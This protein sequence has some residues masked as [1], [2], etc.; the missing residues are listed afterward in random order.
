MQYDY[1]VIILNYNSFELLDRA[2][3]TVRECAS[4]TYRICIVDNCSSRKDEQEELMT[5]KADDVDILLLN[6][7]D[8]YGAGNNRAFFYLRKKYN[9][10]FTVIMNPDIELLDNN[11][12]E[13]IIK[14]AECNNAVGGQP[15]VWNYHYGDDPK[16]QINIGKVADYS[17]LCVQSSLPLRLI[18]KDIFKDTMFLNEMPYDKHIKYEMPSGAF[19][20]IKSNVFEEIGGFDNDTFLYGEET[21][22]AYKLHDH[23]YNLIFCPEYVVKHLQGATTG[24]NRFKWDK[25]RLNNMLESRNIYLKKYLKVGKVK[26]LFFDLLMY[27]DYI[28][29]KIYVSLKA[30]QERKKD[31]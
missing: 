7:N 10:R 3:A 5:L 29:R 24:Y 30:K 28:L 18:F 19:F 16:I 12:I 22:L 27:A 17:T 21:I 15:L 14:A 11:T 26:I 2:I 1:I 4:G 20:L 13:G 31:V 8:G 9:F 25:K 6:T 23:G